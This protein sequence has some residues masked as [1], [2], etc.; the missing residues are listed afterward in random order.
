[1]INTRKITLWLAMVPMLIGGI[2]VL[3]WCFQ[4]IAHANTLILDVKLNEALSIFLAGMA[5]ALSQSSH[6]YAQWARR[7]CSILMVLV[8]G[9]GIDLKIDQI[10]FILMGVVLFFPSTAR[11]MRYFNSFVFFLVGFISLLAMAGHLYNAPVIR[12]TLHVAMASFIMAVGICTAYAR[13]GFLDVIVDSGAGGRTSRRLI[14]ILVF[15]LLSLWWLCLLVQRT[16]FYGVEVG[17]AIIIFVSLNIVGGVVLWASNMIHHWE[18][19][20][21]LVVQK[22]VEAAKIKSSFASMVSHELHSPLAVIKGAIEI[23]EDGLDGPINSSQKHHLEMADISLDRLN[24]L[25]D[26][27]LD[28]QE[29]EAGHVEFSKV[30]HDMNVMISETVNGFEKVAVAQ[31]KMLIQNLSDNLPE[32]MCDKGAII[33][34][35][36]NFLNNALK[37]TDHGSITVSSRQEEKEVVVSV[38]DQGVGIRPKDLHKLFQGFSQIHSEQYKAPGTGL[39]LA[40]SKKIIEQHGGRIGVESKYGKGSTFY[41]ALP[42]I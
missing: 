34:V 2:T 38:T 4:N 11:G 28:F 16:G 27:V 17:F 29:L 42:V 39:E 14:S 23:V 31:K 7:V 13:V 36:T 33:H 20:H 10:F 40:I 5:L 8:A 1:M 12:M 18:G 9:F 32:V 35:L 19:E 26:N 41:F 37:F 24:N 22:M 6:Q 15:A 25:I 3:L 30:F 21:A